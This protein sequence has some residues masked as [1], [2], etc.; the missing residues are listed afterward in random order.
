M[1]DLATEHTVPSDAANMS[2]K[3]K[4]LLSTAMKRTSEWWFNFLS[5]S[6]ESFSIF[7]VEINLRICDVL[8]GSFL[9]RFLVM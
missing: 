6:Q 8:I 3:K 9:R 4:E 1:V 5:F 2:T 7:A